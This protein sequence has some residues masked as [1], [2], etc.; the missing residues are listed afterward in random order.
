MQRI[1]AIFCF[2]AA[3]AAIASAA[4]IYSVAD[5]GTLG[6]SQASA[7]RINQSGHAAGWSHTTAGDIQ[8][9]VHGTAGI[10]P[11]MASGQSQANGMNNLG[12]V[13]GSVQEHGRSTAALWDGGTLID[14]GT[15]GGLNASAMDINDAGQIVGSASIPSGSGRAFLYDGGSMKDLGTLGGASSSSAT[16]INSS[17]QI[18]GWSH[19]S[20]G[21][22]RAFLWST[23]I[24]M[25]SIGGFGS[26]AMD[27]NDAGQVVGHSRIATGYLHAFVYSD[28]VTTDLGT[29]GGGS[30]YA[31]GINNAGDVV[32]YSWTSGGSTRAFLYRNGILLDLNELVAADG[33]ELSEAY[34][35]NDG[36]QI[37]GSGLLNGQLRAFRLDPLAGIEAAE[38][39]TI[40]NPEPASWALISTGA[41]LLL[42]PR[43]RR[44]SNRS[45]PI[46]PQT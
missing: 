27:I 46:S 43:I 34:G 37:V 31:Y 2:A 13:V 40:E 11:L 28:G 12:A 33:W 38:Q 4:P 19:W 6:G 20:S 26:Y 30:S 41:A 25:Q 10:S 1:P 44:G 7:Y 15:L 23:D 32:G 17:G 39:P 14:L 24:G 22:F 16:A 5:L 3:L 36:G 8:A 18:V 9:F 42:I 21:A 45:P 35:I 29:L